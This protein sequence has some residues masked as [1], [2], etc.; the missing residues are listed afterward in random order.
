MKTNVVDPLHPT[1]VRSVA[2]FASVL[3]DCH[4]G[5]G[6]GGDDIGLRTFWYRGHRDAAWRLEPS[7]LREPYVSNPREYDGRFQT[8]FCARGPS[9]FGRGPPECSVHR[10]A[11]MQHHGLPTRLLDWTES[12]LVA[13]YF[14]VRGESSTDSAVWVLDASALSGIGPLQNRAIPPLGPVYNVESLSEVVSWA[15]GTIETF[16]RFEE[17]IPIPLVPAYFGLRDTSQRGR[18]T[19]HGYSAGQLDELAKELAFGSARIRTL[20]WIRIPNEYRQE[21]RAQLFHF[22][23]SETTIYPDL[24]GLARELLFSVTDGLDDPFKD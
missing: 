1:P 19:L 15:D 14:A 18:F 6:N 3:L 11:L 21:I 2:E 12:A 13:L 20:T 23:I 16:R 10:Y 4:A 8:E 9:L 24:D 7:L 22:G 17:F 5:F